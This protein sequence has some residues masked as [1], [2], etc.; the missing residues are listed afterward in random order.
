MAVT[1]ASTSLELKASYM[2]LC[3]VKNI[4]KIVVVIFS[5]IIDIF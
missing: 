5:C 3:S 4:Q 2:A 1:P